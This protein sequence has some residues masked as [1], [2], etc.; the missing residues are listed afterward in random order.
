[1]ADSAEGKDPGNATAGGTST[2]RRDADG[3]GAQEGSQEGASGS[4]NVIAMDDLPEEMRGKEPAQVQ[5]MWN[6]AAR[7]LENQ[8]NENETLKSELRQMREQLEN[9]GRRAPEPETPPEPD[10]S[11]DEIRDKIFDDPV[12]AVE[13]VVRKKFGPLIDRLERS[14]GETALMRMSKKIGSDFDDYEDSVR[15]ILANTSGPISDQTV[16]GAY[17]MA[18]GEKAVQS[19]QERKKKAASSPAPTPEV[20]ESDAPKLSSLQQQVARSMGMSEDEF[21]HYMN[22]D[23]LEL[24]ID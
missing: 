11:P 16:Y 20:N 6:A 14:T 21:T 24:G 1:M 15:A 10:L 23:G 13:A 2:E 12:S 8:N 9:L 18:R 22:A 17:L 5:A 3:G 4:R 19:D 7:A